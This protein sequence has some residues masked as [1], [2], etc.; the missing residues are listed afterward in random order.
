VVGRKPFGKGVTV[1]E[2]VLAW[3]VGGLNIDGSRIGSS[4]KRNI[5]GCMKSKSVYARKLE[6]WWNG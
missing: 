2:N 6:A 3:G 4:E 5:S 1:A